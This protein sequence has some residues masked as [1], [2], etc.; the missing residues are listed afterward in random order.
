M[1]GFSPRLP[2]KFETQQGYSLIRDLKTLTKQN[3][4]ILLMT[5]PG[6]RIM[7]GDFGV[8]IKRLLFEN[9][10]D[11]KILEFESRLQT[12]VK[13]YLPYIEI[14]SIDYSKT[15]QDL[16]LLFADI[17]LFITP[18]GTSYNIIVESDG[19]IVNIN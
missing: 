11:I 6:E 10:S 9:F 1:S 5:N 19:N 16:G 15:N 8:G 12:Q 17:K 4:L 14:I 3:F 7:D 13:K 2:L 18:L